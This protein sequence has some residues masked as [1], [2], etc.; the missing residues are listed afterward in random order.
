MG[1][2]RDRNMIGKIYKTWMPSWHL[3]RRRLALKDARLQFARCGYRLDDLADSQLEAAL[4][5][6]ESKIEEV[7]LTAKRMYWALRRISPDGELFRQRRRRTEPARDEGQ[8]PFR[9]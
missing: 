5:D 9:V 2:G 6:G 8:K 7:P 3:R 1:E 4:I